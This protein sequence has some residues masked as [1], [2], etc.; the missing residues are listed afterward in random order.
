M[1]DLLKNMYS[2]EFITELATHIR[3]VEPSFDSTAFYRDVLDSEWGGRELKQRMDH[4]ARCIRLHLPGDFRRALEQLVK[5]IE[6]YR[7]SRAMGFTDMFFPH[8]VELYG[9]GDPEVSLPAL[10]IFTRSSSSEFAIRP[11]IL[12]YPDRTMDQMLQWSRHDN[13][14]VR[15]L[16]SEGCRP[17]LPWA[18]ALKNFQKDPS[19]IF[20]IL[21]NLK[22]DPSDYVRRSVANNLNDI[23]KD[24]P[25]RVLSVVSQW[26]GH[27]EATDRLV[28]HACR[29]LLRQGH[30]RALALLGY[31]GAPTADIEN[32]KI[33]PKRIS[34]GAAVTMHFDFRPR[35]KG[36]YRLTYAV[37]YV[38][39]RG[40][41]SRKVYMLKSVDAKDGHSI[42]IRH[43][44]S[45][46]DR[47]TRR[48]YP[49][50]HQVHVMVNGHIRASAVVTLKT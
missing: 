39:A 17:R 15:R 43:R 4:I 49:G 2:R 44:R 29:G 37:D 27:S 41:V 36:R 14:H 50:R 48:H 28:R 38:T 7:Q 6:R 19:P 10:E 12:R 8:F 26:I 47:T 9:L 1:A 40:G 11:F 30:S 3:L 21:E 24:H 23:S 34:R 31:G 42:T 32:L 45:F 22:F 33:T 46:A 25:D 20:P 35:R 5:V 16:A 18:I 13:H